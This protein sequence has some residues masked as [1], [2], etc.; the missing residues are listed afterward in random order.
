MTKQA[1]NL[2]AICMQYMQ[3]VSK[4]KGLAPQNADGTACFEAAFHCQM[5]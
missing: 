4:S 5:R 1:I 3:D 2:N